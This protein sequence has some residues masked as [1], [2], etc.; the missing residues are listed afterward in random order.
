MNDASEEAAAKNRE[1]QAAYRER[2]KAYRKAINLIV[3]QNTLEA[4]KAIAR[5]ALADTGQR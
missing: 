4:A 5:D 2:F 3:S 1:K